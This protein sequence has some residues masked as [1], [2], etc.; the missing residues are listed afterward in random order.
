MESLLGCRLGTGFLASRGG[1][2]RKLVASILEGRVPASRGGIP[3][4]VPEGRVR[5]SKL[6]STGIPGGV[7]EGRVPATRLGGGEVP[8]GVPEGRVPATRL[9]SAGISLGLFKLLLTR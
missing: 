3:G 7:P 2:C 5:P 9:G 1:V 6:V 8:G 4:G